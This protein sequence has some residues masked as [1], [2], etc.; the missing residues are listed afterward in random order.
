[1]RV[2]LLEINW[3][4]RCW[5]VQAHGPHVT[6]VEASGAPYMTLRNALEAGEIWRTYDFYDSVAVVNVRTGERRW[7][8]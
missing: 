7:V 3:G 8:K 1:M 5:E 2:G 6:G 4:E